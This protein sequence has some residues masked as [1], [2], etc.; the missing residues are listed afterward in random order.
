MPLIVIHRQEVQ[1]ANLVFIELCDKLASFGPCARVRRRGEI[2]I[3]DTRISIRCGDIC[4]MAGLRLDYYNTDSYLAS[5]FLSVRCGM[6]F[7]S[8]NDI[9]KILGEIYEKGKGETLT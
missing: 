9:F 6:E 8:I 3:L 5:E 2:D 7:K 4:R 1:D